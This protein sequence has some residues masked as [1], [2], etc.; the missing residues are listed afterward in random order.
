VVGAFRALVEA[1]GTRADLAAITGPLAKRSAIWNRPQPGSPRRKTPRRRRR[2][3]DFCA[4]SAWGAG[5]RH[6]RAALIA[7]DAL[8]GGSSEA[9]F[10]S[11]KIATAAFFAQR[12][13]PQT[14]GL[15]S[16]IAA[17]KATLMALG[18][19]AF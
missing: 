2:A 7:A 4:C 13:L 16:A 3:S 9:D 18:E 8:A 19:A 10:Y 15:R 11:A 17:G 14:A 1:E 5:F 12:I 6:A